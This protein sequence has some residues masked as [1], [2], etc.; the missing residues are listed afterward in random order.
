MMGLGVKLAIFYMMRNKINPE[1]NS[2]G[3][4]I[5]T[6]SSAGVYGFHVAPLYAASKHAI[7]G[8]VRSLWRYLE[9]ENI[10]IN[11]LAPGVIGL[12]LFSSNFMGI[13]LTNWA[14]TNIAPDKALFKSMYTTPMSTA[15]NAVEKLLG[16]TSLTGRV[17]ELHGPDFSFAEQKE[18][19]DEGTKNN[20]EMF[21]K[22]GY[23]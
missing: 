12:F 13:L 9:K 2:R 4:I 5:C 7:V 11:A 15:I 8:L 16:D 20:I 17:V 18:F 23:A 19:A 14:A 6:A 22:L 1:T 21:W 10:Q 3:S